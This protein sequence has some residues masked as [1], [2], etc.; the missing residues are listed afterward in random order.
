MLR[1]AVPHVFDKGV[2]GLTSINRSDKGAFPPRLHSAWDPS[3][4]SAFLSFAR[5]TNSTCH[6]LASASI[7]ARRSAR[8]EKKIDDPSQS[9][10]SVSAGG[11]GAGSGATKSKRRDDEE[12]GYED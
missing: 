2:P 3:L 10:S 12:S 11:A 6:T 7:C 1:R 8:D 5:E 9:A 4:M